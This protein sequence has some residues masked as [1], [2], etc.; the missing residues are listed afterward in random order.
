LSGAVTSEAAMNASYPNIPDADLIAYALRYLADDCNA[1][2]PKTAKRMR[3]LADAVEAGTWQV[4]DPPA[5][6]V[7]EDKDKRR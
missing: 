4:Q 3:E 6:G 1:H 2:R 5:T 7:V